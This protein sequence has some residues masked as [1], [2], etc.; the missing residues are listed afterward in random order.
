[1]NPAAVR[2][3]ATRIA[4]QVHRTPVRTSATLDGRTGAQVLLKDEAVQ[5]TGSFKARGALNRLLTLP[6]EAR[7]RGLVCVTAGNHGAAGLGGRPGRGQG[8]RGHADLQPGRQG[9]RLAGA[10]APRWSSTATPPWRPSP[11][12]SGPG[13]ARPHLRPPSTTPRSSPARAPSAWSRRGRRPR[14]GCPGRRRRRAH[15]RHRPGRPRRQPRLPRGRGR[16]REG[17]RPHR[18]PGAGRPV[19]IVPRSV[20]DG[21]CAPSPGRSLPAL[22]PGGRGRA[23]VRGRA[24]GRGPVRDGARLKVVVEPAGAATVAALLAR[25][26]R[27]SAGRR[28][29]TVLTGGNV[30][31][32]AIALSSRRGTDRLAGPPTMCTIT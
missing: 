17:G 22:P 5:K 19:L 15:L 7:E 29:G 21:L 2:S 23:P 16:A 6:D 12:A 25:Q 3:A 31:L 4:G 24:A 26:G 28:V 10:T 1:M 14:S 13:R 27:R 11:S 32:G 9:G 20:A 30:G 18:G 8:D